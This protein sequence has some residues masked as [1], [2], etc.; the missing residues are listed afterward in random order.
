ML[1]P[2]R[3][4]VTTRDAQGR[5]KL[6]VEGQAPASVSHPAWPG[7]GATRGA[8][9]FGPLVLLDNCRISRVRSSSAS[10]S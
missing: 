7:M 9:P 5:S 2:V 8:G 10:T 1:K 3:R 4:L 6:L